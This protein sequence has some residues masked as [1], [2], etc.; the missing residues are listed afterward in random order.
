MRRTSQWLKTLKK[1][2][3]DLIYISYYHTNQSERRLVNYLYTHLKPLE[4]Q[5]S[6]TLWSRDNIKP[7]SSDES[8][9]IYTAR[10]NCRV[11][12]VIV[13]AD[14]LASPDYLQELE[15][16]AAAAIQKEILLLWQQYNDCHYNTTPLGDI[17]PILRD[18][19]LEGQNKTNLNNH[20][21]SISDVINQAWQNWAPVSEGLE[22]L[23][24]TQTPYQ[25]L[26]QLA[27][28]YT[29]L[30]SK[31]VV[32]YLSK[33]ADH[34]Y[35]HDGLK[36][37]YPNLAGV[38][39]WDT[40]KT[41]FR[42]GASLD[43]A[44]VEEFAKQLSAQ[45]D[46]GEPSS[47]VT[48]L[49]LVLKPSGQLEQ[50][51]AYF[52]WSAYCRSPADED[53]KVLPQQELGEERGLL[54]FEPTNNEIASASDVLTKLVEW[55][56]KNSSKPLFEI[57]APYQLVNEDWDQLQVVDE[58]ESSTPFQTYH[59][60]LRPYE[61]LSV[62]FNS[63][64]PY[65]KSKISKLQQGG[66]SW[67]SDASSLTPQTIKASFSNEHIVAIRK[68]KSPTGDRSAR[69]EWLKSV[70][71]SMVPLAIWYRAPSDAASTESVEQDFHESLLKLQ[72]IQPGQEPTTAPPCCPD[73]N[74]LA[75][76]CTEH[77]ISTVTLLVDDPGRLPP[78]AS[79]P[80]QN[81]ILPPAI[82]A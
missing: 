56:Q 35:G 31:E 82:S 15:A 70:I 23:A 77:Q 38:L 41:Y 75:R 4:K 25:Q 36:N 64:R 19:K 58:M 24:N 30:S 26:E 76:K 43:A 67:L 16:L 40:L 1:T 63:K 80:G 20:L 51:R 78:T 62:N 55:A 65:L 18:I 22:G 61:R 52:E 66:G 27:I 57:Y 5:N 42:D 45:A 68:S 39:T 10:K 79:A 9:Q 71:V 47:Q 32:Q 13:S 17:K 28:E 54:C 60:L 59:Y 33:A 49:A 48:Y 74:L 81:P 3:R 37:K 29:H 12:V 44:L 8:A 53:F 21:Y 6:L 14:Y 7:G 50:G 72:L 34:L 2:M 69:D 11:A 46:D 73:F